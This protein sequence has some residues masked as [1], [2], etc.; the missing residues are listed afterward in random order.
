MHDYLSD[1]IRSFHSNFPQFLHIQRRGVFSLMRNCSVFQRPDRNPYWGRAGY[2]NLLLGGGPD[3]TG[4]RLVSPAVL[5]LACPPLIS[6]C[7]CRYVC[8]E[9]YEYKDMT[10]HR[11]E[12]VHHR[13]LMVTTNKRIEIRAVRILDCAQSTT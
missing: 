10:G 1:Q 2:C 7:D 6:W 3:K 11:R 13:Y 5:F 8:I 4:V 12:P 9:T